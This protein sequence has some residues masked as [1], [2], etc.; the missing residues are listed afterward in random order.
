MQ[1]GMQMPWKYVVF[2]PKLKCPLANPTPCIEHGF[3]N[4]W[5]LICWEPVLAS[6]L[7]LRPTLRWGQ[8]CFGLLGT[9]TQ[10]ESFVFT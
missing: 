1:L 5:P 3:A 2:V 7:G 4:I 9:Q 10:V 8:R 6:Y